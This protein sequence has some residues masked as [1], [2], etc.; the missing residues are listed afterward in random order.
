MSDITDRP[1]RT[2]LETYLRIVETK[3]FGAEIYSVTQPNERYYISAQGQCCSLSMGRP[4][5]YDHAAELLARGADF[6]T[7]SDKEVTCATCPRAGCAPVKPVWLQGEDLNRQVDI[8][9][10]AT[11][12]VIIRDRWNQG[13]QGIGMPGDQRSVLR[14]AFG[15]M[16]QVDSA[17][18]HSKVRLAFA[19]TCVPEV[20]DSKPSSAVLMACNPLLT[21]EIEEQKPKLLIACGS[22]VLK[23]LGIKS[24]FMDVRGRI[25][26]PEDTG[27]PAPLMVTFSEAAL[28]AAPGIFQTFLQDLENVYARLKRGASARS[29]ETLTKDYTLPK[30]M[31]E[32]LEVIEHIYNYGDD[33][34]AAVDWWISVDTE[35]TSL[36][37]EKPTSKVIAFCFGWDDG[38][39]TTVL[40]DHPAAPPEYLERLPELRAA[41]ARL[42]ASTKPKTLHNAKFDLKWCELKYGMPVNNVRWCSLLGEH[43]LDEDKKGNYGLKA[44][45]AVWLPHFCGYEDKLHDILEAQDAGLFEEVDAK[46]EALPEE[47]AEYA[48]QLKAY[49][50]E[51]EEFQGRQLAWELANGAYEVAYAKYQADAARYKA[52]MGLW[53][54]RERR[55]N[56]PVKPKQPKGLD[57]LDAAYEDYVKELAKYDAALAAWEAWEAP[58]KPVRLVE[59][60][61]RPEPLGSAPREPADPRSKKERA[62]VTDGGYEKIDV[63]ELQVYG[64]VDGDVTRQLTKLQRRRLIQEQ[65]T[66]AKKAAA[67][68]WGA[69]SEVIVTKVAAKRN[70]K[71]LTVL[72]VDEVRKKYLASEEAKEMKKPAPADLM[73]SHAIPASRVLGRMEYEGTT[74]DQVYASILDKALTDII[75]RTK[76]AVEK[77]VG[78]I[79]AS[80]QPFNIASSAHLA[81]VVYEM[82]WTHPSGKHMPPVPCLEFTAKTRQRST[83]EKALKPYIKYKDE[84]DIAT[85]KMAKVVVPEG[86]FLEQVFLYK[87]AV[88]ARDTFLKNLRMLSKPDGRV[89]TSFHINGTGTGRLSCFIGSM[90]VLTRRGEVPIRNVRVGDYV[91]THAR[92]WREVLAVIDKGVRTVEDFH[93]SNGTVLS[94]T[95]DHRMYTTSGEWVSLG[96]LADEYLEEVA[97]V[98]GESRARRI[99]V[100]GHDSV[101]HGVR[102]RQTRRHHAGYGESRD[103]RGPQGGG[104]QS[105]SGVALL[106]IEDGRPEPDAGEGAAEA[107]QLE[108]GVRQ[109]HGLLDDH[110]RREAAVGAPR[111]DGASVGSSTAPGEVGCAPHRRGQDEQRDRQLGVGNSSGAQGDSQSPV[112]AVGV[113]VTAR[114][115]RRDDRVYDLTVEGD[116][117]FVVEGV[118]AHNS[119]DMNLQNIPKK[120]AG[121]SIKKL[122]VPDDPENFVFVNADYKG[123][124][125]RVF[126]AYARDEKLI[127]AL[128]NGLDMHSFFASLVFKRDYEDYQNRDN[129]KALPNDQAYHVVVDGELRGLSGLEYRALLDKERSAIKRVVFGILYGAGEGKIAETIGISR[130]EARAIIEK[131]F[132]MFPAI[133]FYIENVHHSALV[134]GYVD[135]L[136]GRRR[137]FPLISTTRHRAR[138]Q[139]QATN[140]KIQSTSSDIVIGQVIEMYEMIHSDRTWPEWGIHEPLHKLGVR[141]LLTVHDSIAL[142]W[143]KSIIRSLGPW[144]KYYGE[145]RVREKYPWLPVPF[146]MDVEVGPSYGECQALEK[147]LAQL[148]DDEHPLVVVEED[149]GLFEE[150]MDLH[151]LRIDAFEND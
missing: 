96:E 126:T 141:L 149:E 15:H 50:A 45:T 97:G 12:P 19:A 120:L 61:K 101:A 6:S 64:A 137:R 63:H 108:G 29:L 105:V 8:L 59:R 117:S 130:D 28:A 30:T 124:E 129:A 1:V 34:I 56:K 142:Q 146:A 76:A 140:F 21:R 89:H 95:A 134:D 48:A 93:L 27:L 31:D 90:R 55:G 37:P 78:G 145:T 9:F 88:K 92:R 72:E 102:D 71:S 41:V 13:F 116:H 83:T 110:P 133:K 151:E 148:K 10:I 123:A 118:Y 32:A 106:K 65:A 85:G 58:P 53:E 62:F 14:A 7:M 46:I 57:V 33:R 42:L 113:A 119:S 127:E 125:V 94:A 47:Y 128:N 3:M 67:A 39:S 132:E 150:H 4:V 73:L 38:K 25:L 147:Y 2:F 79:T 36:R 112:P 18:L 44:L 138:S 107:P 26:E 109:R 82:G 104:P 103:Q 143:P 49:R 11:Q 87:K 16:A 135:T 111:G 86:Y 40:F 23:Q 98:R 91:W 99:D 139:R 52:E 75:D 22:V 17:R 81:D 66:S 80:G 69:H 54:Q 51:L 68:R 35:T 115:A 5:P 84:I 136:F 100:H 122:F 43:L 131:L 74:I 70:V 77:M 60:P 144:L 24:K 114:Y 20:V 121:W